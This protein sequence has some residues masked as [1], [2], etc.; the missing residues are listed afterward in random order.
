MASTAVEV[1][2]LKVFAYAP[3]LSTELK[4]RYSGSPLSSREHFTAE[5]TSVSSCY[6]SMR[7]KLILVICDE[8]LLCG[9]AV[10]SLLFTMSFDALLFSRVHCRRRDVVFSVIISVN[11]LAVLSKTMETF[12]SKKVFVYLLLQLFFSNN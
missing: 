6:R 9:F 11:S 7:C 8:L 10:S 2:C 3:F 1:S 4:L 5:S 12:Q